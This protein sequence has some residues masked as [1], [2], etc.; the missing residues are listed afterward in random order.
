MIREMELPYVIGGHGKRVGSDAFD[1]TY[2]YLVELRDEVREA[3]DNDVGI[4]D[5]VKT[6][7]M[8]AFAS[9]ALYDVMHAQNVEAAYR[10]LEWS[11]E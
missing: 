11:D 5:A 6:I 8:E 1:L 4:E 9:A 3:I 10:M 7:K 2:R